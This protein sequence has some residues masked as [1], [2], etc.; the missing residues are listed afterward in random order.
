MG[1]RLSMDN[2]DVEG[3]D[4]G[5]CPSRWVVVVVQMRGELS[6]AILSSRLGTLGHGRRPQARSRLV[7][8]RMSGRQGVRA[9]GYVW[10]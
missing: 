9:S 5:H 2:D 6:T 1:A 10:P 4:G 7:R 3:K 8:F